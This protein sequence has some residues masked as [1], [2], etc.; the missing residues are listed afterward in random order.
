MKEMKVLL[1]D[2][3]KEFVKSLSERMQIRDVQSKVA[4][5]GDEALQTMNEEL[6]DVMVLD[7]KMPG[8]DGM[9]LLRRN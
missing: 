5:G 7:L 2:D 3:E 6:P 1:V 9:E 4:Y 8:M